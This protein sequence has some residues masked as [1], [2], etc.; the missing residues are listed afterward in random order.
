MLPKGKRRFLHKKRV[1]T[2]E[3]LICGGCIAKYGPNLC[4]RCE[5]DDQRTCSGW[6]AWGRGALPWEHHHYRRQFVLEEEL[7]CERE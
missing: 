6:H 5:L 2:K 4:S 3:C 7:E 1:G